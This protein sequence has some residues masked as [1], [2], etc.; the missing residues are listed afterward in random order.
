MAKTDN[1]APVPSTTLPTNSREYDVENTTIN[2][3]TKNRAAFKTYIF[4]TV[5]I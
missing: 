3:P 5:S 2:K 1:T 4:P